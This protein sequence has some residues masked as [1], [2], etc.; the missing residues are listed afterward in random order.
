MVGVLRGQQHISRKNLPKYPPSGC[1]QWVTFCFT[2]GVHVCLQVHSGRTSRATSS[3][4]QWTTSTLFWTQWSGDFV[5]KWQ[6]CWLGQNKVMNAALGGRAKA[7]FPNSA[8][9]VELPRA[10]TFR[11]RPPPMS[12]CRFKTPKLSRSK[13][14]LGLGVGGG[15]TPNFKWRG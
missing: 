1:V 6:L 15:G 5:I 9:T 14:V 3:A 8:Y 12:Y 11:K 2:T 4:N 13:L 7:R 10:T